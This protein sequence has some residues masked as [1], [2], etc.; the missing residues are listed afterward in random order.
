[1]WLLIAP[2]ILAMLFKLYKGFV[3]NSFAQRALDADSGTKL[4]LNAGVVSEDVEA[5]ASKTETACSPRTDSSSLQNVYN[6]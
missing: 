5:K 6:S 2:I 4:N 1:M 3:F